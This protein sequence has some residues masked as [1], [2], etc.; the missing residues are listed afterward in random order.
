MQILVVPRYDDFA[1]SWRRTKCYIKNIS[2]SAAENNHSPLMTT[3]Q[4]QTYNQYSSLCVHVF[5]DYVSRDNSL[6]ETYPREKK[7]AFEEDVCPQSKQ[8]FVALTVL[9]LR[10]FEA[11]SRESR[12]I[13]H[14]PERELR[15]STI[16][17]GDPVD[18]YQGNWTKV[19]IAISVEVIT[20][21]I[22]ADVDICGRICGSDA[23]S[24]SDENDNGTP[25]PFPPPPPPPPP[26][27]PQENQI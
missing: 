27:L 20:D 13:P 14:L 24:D 11:P 23:R 26:P 17:V 9:L 12:R 4:S 1:Q 18:C 3:D 5:V 25:P 10:M 21:N 22:V 8:V 7:L 19:A 16:R 6:R 2:F 15:I